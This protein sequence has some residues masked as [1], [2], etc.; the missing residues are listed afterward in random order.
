MPLQCRRRSGS[1]FERVRRALARA[2]TLSLAAAL[3]L[4]A[5]A[6]QWQSRRRTCERH[7]EVRGDAATHGV[8]GITV[9]GNLPPV[10]RG[11]HARGHWAG[12]GRWTQAQ[13]GPGLPRRVDFESCAWSG[14]PRHA[15]APGRSGN[16]CSSHIVV[17][18]LTTVSS[19]LVPLPLQLEVTILPVATP[20]RRW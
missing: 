11:C 6:S 9:V 14:L 5:I 7:R 8:T 15:R 3:A 12:P 1:Q 20:H 2:L 10:A 17:R 4:P 18:W 13:A 19:W 16:D